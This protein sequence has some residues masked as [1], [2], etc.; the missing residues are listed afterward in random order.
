VTLKSARK[1]KLSAYQ[2][3]GVI[4]AYLANKV[5]LSRVVGPFDSPSVENL[6]ISS[7]GVIPKKVQLGKW[8]S[9]QGH[10]VNDGIDPDSW[11]LQYIKIDDIIM[12]VSKFGPG[13]LMAKFDIMS[14]VHPLDHHLLGLKWHNLYYMDLALP[15][16]LRSAPAIFNSVADEAEWILVNNYGIDDPLHYLD[17]FIT[18]APANSSVCAS[19]GLF[20][21]LQGWISHYIL[22]NAWVQLRVW[23]SWE[24]N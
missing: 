8:R 21:W 16:R 20:Q 10:S 4:D 22:R 24:L 1:N 14:A 2:H 11:H 15:F 18:A 7:F 5:R 6:H 3:L 13:A 19:Y 12:M 9:P 23:W 17:D